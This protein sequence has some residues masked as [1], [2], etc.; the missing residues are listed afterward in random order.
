MTLMLRVVNELC[1]VLHV[2]RCDLGLWK[3]KGCCVINRIMRMVMAILMLVNTVM[4]LSLVL[5]YKSRFD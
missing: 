3:K 4:L 2:V 1:F 5:S